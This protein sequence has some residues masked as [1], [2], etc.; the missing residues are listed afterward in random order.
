[1]DQINENKNVENVQK[2]E[3]K[4][5][6][7]RRNH[8]N[9]DLWIHVDAHNSE[10]NKFM[11]LLTGISTLAA[12]SLVAVSLIQHNQTVMLTKQN[13]TLIAQYGQLV[14]QMSTTNT[15]ALEELE[16]GLDAIANSIDHITVNVP[17]QGAAPEGNQEDVPVA[18]VDDSAF[19][20]VVVMN[21]GTSV[22]PLGLRIAGIYENSPAANA[23]LRAGDIIMTIEGVSI[24]SFETMSGIIDTKAPGDVINI[25]FAR[26]QDGAVFF[27]D[28]VLTLDSASNYDLDLSEETPQP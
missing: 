20:G 27:N 11:T 28:A 25:R 4:I 3:Q 23:G 21:D 8:N 5:R 22:T 14:S 9:N 18:P 6:H 12:L 13:E 19:M 7:P 24:D 16:A 2:N 1:M 26:A 17:N 10:T 15:K